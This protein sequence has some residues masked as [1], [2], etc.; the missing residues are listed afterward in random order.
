MRNENVI[1][2]NRVS[3][4]IAF[5]GLIVVITNVFRN[6]HFRERPVI[7]ILHDP[8]ISV[9][10]IFSLIVYLTRKIESRVIQY[11]HIAVFMMNAALALIDGYE[12]F[13]GMGFIFL[14][15]ALSYRYGLL[16]KYS[17]IKLIFIALFTLFFL[18][19]SIFRSG[20]RSGGLQH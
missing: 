20:K 3:A 1:I 10:F 7:E 2:Q 8:S 11:I 4:M 15:M 14:T 13:H 18:E 12:S 19:Y 6:I 9:V 17:R 5:T 16:E